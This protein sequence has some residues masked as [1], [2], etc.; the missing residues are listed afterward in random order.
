[1]RSCMN[2]RSA[3]GILVKRIPIPHEGSSLFSQLTCNQATSALAL[4][5]WR[6]GTTTCSLNCSLGL[7]GFSQRINAPLALMSSSSAT[8][9]PVLS[10]TTATQSMWILESLRLSLFTCYLTN[11]SMRINGFKIPGSRG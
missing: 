5:G 3:R 4:K 8:L 11:Y 10:Q 9:L 1:M 2:W 6:L 7:S